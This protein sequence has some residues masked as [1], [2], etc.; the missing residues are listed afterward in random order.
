MGMEITVID[1]SDIVGWMASATR[2]GEVYMTNV[3]SMVSNVLMRLGSN[4]I[5]RLNI[6]DHGNS[7][8]IEIGTDWITPRS[9]PTFVPTLTRL[10]SKF[11]TGGFVHLQHCN[12]GS[13]HALLC[14]LSRVFG[15]PVVAGTGKHNPVYR[16]N[17]GHY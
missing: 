16:F 14:E 1:D 11:S 3:T 15:V 6:L 9:L 4:T 8:G 10:R 7:S 5:D 2:F 17:L 13:N 12:V